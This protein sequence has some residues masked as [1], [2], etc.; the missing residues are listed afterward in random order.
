MGDTLYSLGVGDIESRRDATVFVLFG[1]SG[2]DLTGGV[3]G[4]R[5]DAAGGLSK[6]DSTGGDTKPTCCPSACSC[7]S[8]I[9][10][11]SIP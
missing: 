1:L 8:S 7:W 2:G 9:C 6:G 4:L 3:V 11:G 5:R 10:E